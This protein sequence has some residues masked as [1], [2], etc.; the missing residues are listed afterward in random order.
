MIYGLNRRNM[1]CRIS[2]CSSSSSQW[3]K[4]CDP[5]SRRSRPM[6]HAMLAWRLNGTQEGVLFGT[7]ASYV[8]SI[9]ILKIF[10][11]ASGIL[12]CLQPPMHTFGAFQYSLGMTR[13]WNSNQAKCFWDARTDGEGVLCLIACVWKDCFSFD[14]SQ[15]AP[16]PKHIPTNES[17]QHDVATNEKSLLQKAF[18]NPSGCRLG[19][20]HFGRPVGP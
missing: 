12:A 15:C 20:P 6:F 4:K 2:S 8:A 17:N 10:S 11:F 16:E 14:L 18:L 3:L 7:S 19:D 13:K 5:M 1:S 9:V